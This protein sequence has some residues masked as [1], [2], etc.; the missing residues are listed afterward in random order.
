MHDIIDMVPEGIKANKA[1]TILMH[2]S[3]SWVR[4]S[5]VHRALAQTETWEG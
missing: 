1:R 3:E 4:L 5:R 2:M